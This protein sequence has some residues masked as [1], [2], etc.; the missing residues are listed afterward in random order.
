M[1]VKISFSLHN[2]DTKKENKSQYNYMSFCTED[3]ILSGAEIPKI[4]N[5]L[6]KTT[7]VA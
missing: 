5:P 4:V 1:V 7:F 3:H 6:A 2:K